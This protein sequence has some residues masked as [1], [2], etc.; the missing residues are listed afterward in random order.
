M[1]FWFYMKFSCDV[2]VH[3]SY[4]QYI[5]KFK[6]DTIG[7]TSVG[8][9]TMSPAQQKLIKKVDAVKFHNRA[10]KCKQ[11]KKNDWEN[12]TQ[13]KHRQTATGKSCPFRHTSRGCSTVNSN[14]FAQLLS[15]LI[16]VLM[17]SFN[18]GGKLCYNK[19]AATST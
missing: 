1:K 16:M 15:K 4:S 19:Q 13:K 18:S 8:Q 7:V 9:A 12:P 17:C 3:D 11:E 5:V 2:M 14:A 10:T 6:I